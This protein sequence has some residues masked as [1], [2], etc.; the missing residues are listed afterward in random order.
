MM[1]EKSR[2]RER[3]RKKRETEREREKDIKRKWER[4]LIEKYNPGWEKNP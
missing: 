2:E 4:G 1:R 3:E